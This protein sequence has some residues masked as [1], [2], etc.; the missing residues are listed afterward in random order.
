[1]NVLLHLKIKA[2]TRRWCDRRCQA[3]AASDTISQQSLPCA[4]G[5]AWHELDS[6][7]VR[8]HSTFTGELLRGPA[9]AGRTVVFLFRVIIVT[10]SHTDFS[11]QRFVVSYSLP[12]THSHL[13]SGQ[14]VIRCFSPSSTLFSQKILFSENHRQTAM[15]LQS[16]RSPKGK[17]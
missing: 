1:M 2:R 5:Y 16:K 17:G 11:R 9:T 7:V 12:H 10:N 15:Q 13:P 4:K 6:H 3:G 14:R 8:V